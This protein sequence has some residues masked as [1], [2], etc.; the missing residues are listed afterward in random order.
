MN[1]VLNKTVSKVTD[2]SKSCVVFI[3]RFKVSCV[4]SDGI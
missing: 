2:F 1:V 3:I 4:L